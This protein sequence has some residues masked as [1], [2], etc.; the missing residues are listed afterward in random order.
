MITS[1]KENS[2]SMVW[3]IFAVGAALSWGLYGPV[4]HKGQTELGNPFR[5]LLCVG[6]AYF[7]IGVLVPIAA[8]GAQGGLKGFNSGGITWATLGGALGAFGS[9]CIIYA[10]KVG[11]VPSYVMPPAVRG[12]PL[13]NR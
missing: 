4:L 9:I 6:M 2:K 11:G 12:P 1:R 3:V 8:L 7:L 5:A 13:A 10:F